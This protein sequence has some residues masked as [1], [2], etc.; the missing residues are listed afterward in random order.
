MAGASG[1]PDGAATAGG[2]R[3]IMGPP[4][5]DGDGTD[6]GPVAGANGWAGAKPG[7]L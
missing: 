1:V 4:V 2:G 6:D 5:T 7:P 3:I